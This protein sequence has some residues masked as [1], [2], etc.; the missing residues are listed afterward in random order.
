MNFENSTKSSLRLRWTGK[1]CIRFGGKLTTHLRRARSKKKP[2]LQGQSSSSLR[3]YESKIVSYLNGI[4]RSLLT[5]H[6]TNNC[7][8]ERREQEKKCT[9]STSCTEGEITQQK[10]EK[11]EGK[12]KK[13]KRRKTFGQTICVHDLF[14]MPFRLRGKGISRIF[15]MIFFPSQLCVRVSFGFGSS[16]SKRVKVGSF[17]FGGTLNSP[18]KLEQ[19]KLAI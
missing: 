1:S 19:L 4:L 10:C 2:R 5:L 11:W 14:V 3:V 18:K 12:G 16:V 6:T 15:M 9:Q 17:F 13:T 8:N 7:T